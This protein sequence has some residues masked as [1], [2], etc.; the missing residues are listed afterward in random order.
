[1]QALD[2]FC[3]GNES[4]DEG[5]FVL[6]VSRLKAKAKGG[7]TTPRGRVVTRRYP[8]RVAV[9]DALRDLKGVVHVTTHRLDGFAVF[10]DSFCHGWM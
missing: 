4:V 5:S 6:R 2:L 9:C 1:M 10:G 3:H 7:F 8:I